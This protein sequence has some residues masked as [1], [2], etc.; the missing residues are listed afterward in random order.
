VGPEAL[1]PLEAIG[2]LCLLVSHPGRDPVGGA[3]SRGAP[4]ERRWGSPRASV[5]WGLSSC[6]RAFAGISSWAGA[7]GLVLG[8]AF[9]S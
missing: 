8:E 2:K 7:K 1:E 9:E 4:R 3:A 6:A 5:A